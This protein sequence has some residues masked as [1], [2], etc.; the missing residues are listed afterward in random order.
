[1]IEI[2][3]GIHNDICHSS[4]FWGKWSG[5]QISLFPY[6]YE[7]IFGRKNPSTK[8]RVIMNYLRKEWTPILDRYRC[9]HPQSPMPISIATPIWVCWWQG[10]EQMPPMIRKCYELLLKNSNGHPVRLITCYNYRD[11]VDIPVDV[12]QMVET[13]RITV[14]FLSD[15]IRSSLL[16]N[17]GGIWIDATYWVTQPIDVNG[18]TLFTYRQDRFKGQGGI[19]DFNWTCH[20]IGI[21]GP[22]YVFSFIK[23]CL[24]EHVKKHNDII[25]YLLIDF[26]INMAYESFPDFKKLVDDLP[27]YKP[28]IYI[29]PWLFNQSLDEVNLRKILT[30]TPFLKLTYKQEYFNRTDKGEVTYFDWFIN[31]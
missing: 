2:I 29:M 25:E 31:Q 21:G 28:H 15:I 9:P 26:A 8:N 6:I 16:A 17:Y 10:E 1:M 3:R 24:I 18:R 11:I 20:L 23:D 27:D 4:H 22:Y 12:I 7:R 13:N 30:S 14:T 19:N 5:I